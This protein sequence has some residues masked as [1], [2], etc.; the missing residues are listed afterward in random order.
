MNNMVKT[1]Y[2]IFII[3]LITILSCITVYASQSDFTYETQE[4]GT[5]KIKKY[6]GEE[7]DVIVPMMI[8]GKKV[9]TMGYGVF[10]YNNKIK[11][12]ILPETIDTIQQGTFQSCLNL[13][14]VDIYGDVKEMGIKVFYGCRELEIVNFYGG[15]CYLSSYSFYD[16]ANLQYV[17]LPNDIEY[18]GEGCFEYCTKLELFDMPDK[19]IKIDDFAFSYCRNLVLIDVP[20]GVL[21]LG[22]R[23]FGGCSGMISLS[24]P[25]TIT[26]A[27]LSS[28]YTDGNLKY[29]NLNVDVSPINSSDLYLAVIDY[30]VSLGYQP[31]DIEMRDY[32]ETP[33][34]IRVYCKTGPEEMYYVCVNQDAEGNPDIIYTRKID[35]FEYEKG[36]VNRDNKI[37]TSDAL[38]ILRYSAEMVELSYA[39]MRLGDFD[40]NGT[41]S[42]RDALTLLKYVAKITDTL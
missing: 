10:A 38:E 29:S 40:N 23:P 1:L 18:I 12:V 20:V 22:H 15:L 27:E 34:G 19:I 26:E 8:D 24:V 41:A 37:D 30:V 16:C 7:K 21:T 5:I 2:V 17:S 36:D 32:T 11:S 25:D 9:T 31:E 35:I 39:N 3:G 33:L 6:I 4:D 42:A 28:Y 13:E 14:R